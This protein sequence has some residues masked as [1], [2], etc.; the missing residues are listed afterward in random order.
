MG[1]DHNLGAMSR[2]QKRL[3][4][5]NGRQPRRLRR[6]GPERFCHHRLRVSRVP[7]F[8]G[9]ADKI[10][11]ML[12]AL[13]VDDVAALAVCGKSIRE[14][15]MKAPFPT[16]LEKRSA[17]PTTSCWPKAPRKS[18]RRALLGHGRRSARRL[19]RRPAGDLPERDR[20]DDNV[21]KVKEVFASLYN[22]RAI[23]LPRA[24][25]L[26]AQ[27]FLSSACSAW[28]ARTWR[29]RRDVHAGHRIRFPRRGVHHLQ[30]RP[31][32]NAV[33]QGAVNPTSSTSTSRR[34][35]PASRRSC[36]L[37]GRKSQD[38]M[39]YTDV[40]GERVRHRDRRPRSAN[41]FSISD[42]DVR[43]CPPGA[44]HRGHYGRP[45]D[46]EWGKDGVTA[47]CTSCRRARKR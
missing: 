16:E 2:R 41:T 17:P 8:R 43:N 6:Q 29:V 1:S 18:P 36:A 5:G 3:A 33:V 45:M 38:P 19:L 11:A 14:S 26:Q 34:S 39:M 22:D 21:L 42:E 12:N 46:I 15:V 40:P 37:A 24:P 30:L 28:C 7:R 20:A 47:S 25:R 13:D 23:S 4:R 35:T 27:R 44:D 31:R 9:L 10:N 32:R